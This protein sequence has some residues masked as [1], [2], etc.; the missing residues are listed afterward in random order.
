MCHSFPNANIGVITG[1]SDVTVV[2]CDAPGAVATMIERCGDTPLKTNTPSGGT[3]LWYRANGELCANLRPEGL[4]VDVKGVGGFVVVPPS[5]RP[6][7]P[8][9]GRGYQLLSGSWA[10]LRNLPTIGSGGLD[11][12]TPMEAGQPMH[13]RAVREGQ[14]N[15]LLHRLLL[16]HARHCDSIDDLQDVADTINQDF[17]PPLNSA[18]VQKTVR[19]AWRYEQEDNN[20]VGREARALVTASEYQF[21]AAHRHGADALLLLVKLQLSN[22]A[23]AEFSVAP[24]AMAQAKVIPRW[25]PQRYRNAADALVE[26]GR[27]RITHH[28]GRGDGDAKRYAFTET[29]LLLPARAQKGGKERGEGCSIILGPETRPSLIDVERPLRRKLG[30]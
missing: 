30:P 19:S 1:L 2:D 25:G 26:I 18:E 12:R 20:W 4:A 10:D 23:R 28:G 15:R 14:R 27:L 9:A 8:Y 11:V 3:H 7:G 13:L 29:T 16:R 22:W 24:K 21:L 5:V 6:S 17:A